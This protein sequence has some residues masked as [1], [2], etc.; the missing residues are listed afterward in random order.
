MVEAPMFT[1]PLASDYAGLGRRLCRSS[2]G[3]RTEFS[4]PDMYC[5]RDRVKA[6]VQPALLPGEGERRTER[7]ERHPCD[8][9][10]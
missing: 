4:P 10:G 9:E 5:L 6:Q 1:N 7:E 3:D 2:L 8:R